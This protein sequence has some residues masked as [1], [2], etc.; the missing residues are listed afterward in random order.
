MQYTAIVQLCA[1]VCNT[2]RVQLRI[3]TGGRDPGFSI[4]RHLQKV[5]ISISVVLPE[6]NYFTDFVHQK[7]GGGGASASKNETFFNPWC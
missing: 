5:D 1:I 7:N 2:L 3:A 6:E 4:H